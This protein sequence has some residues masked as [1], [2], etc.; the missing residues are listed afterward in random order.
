MALNLPHLDD[1]AR[2]LMVDEI[3]A[4]SAAG[5]VYD[6]NRLNASGKRSTTA[7]SRWSPASPERSLVR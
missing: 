1:R 2:K 3:Q 4:D 6:S 7:P 5:K